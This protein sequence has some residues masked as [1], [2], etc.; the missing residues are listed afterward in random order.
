[1]QA[2]ILA[3]GL[4]SRLKPFTLTFPKP[5]MP[6]GNQPI[7]EILLRQLRAA[8]CDRVTLA[9]NHLAELIMAFCGDGSKFGLQ[10]T[11]SRE[12]EPQ[13]TAAPLRLL[14][15]LDDNFLM[16]N[17]DILTTLS[18][19]SFFERH[20]AQRNEL[21]IFTHEK[22]VPI[23]LGVLELDEHRQFR[24]Y[25]EKPVY[26]FTVSTGIY[27]MSRSMLSLI[28]AQGRFAMPDLVTAAGSA[29]RQIGII[30]DPVRWLDIGRPDDYEVAN[31]LF[32]ANQRE[33]LP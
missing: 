3:G 17:G 32:E 26:R 29:R 33:F 5:L 12:D 1:M 8:G 22:T 11:Y 10:I 7:L 24:R 28:P 13:G 21:T 15:K 25:I 18:F 4:G 20:L 30:D 14:D 19:E 23:D 9:V 2:I 6:I 16:L 27:A 31:E